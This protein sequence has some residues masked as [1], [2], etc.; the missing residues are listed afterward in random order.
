MKVL[1]FYSGA[2]SFRQTQVAAHRDVLGALGRWVSLVLDV[3][4]RLA[5]R[6]LCNLLS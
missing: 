6:L 5:R 3:Q 1:V 2:V 4:H